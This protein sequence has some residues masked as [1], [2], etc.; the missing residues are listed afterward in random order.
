MIAEHVW[1][2]WTIVGEWS[3]A[4][5]PATPINLVDGA[6]WLSSFA[7]AQIEAYCPQ[8]AGPSQ[9]QAGQG[10]FFWNFKIETGYDEWNYL[11][12]VSQSWFSSN[13]SEYNQQFAFSCADLYSVPS[14]NEVKAALVTRNGTLTLKCSLFSF[15]MISLKAFSAKDKEKRPG[16]GPGNVFNGVN[17]GGFLVLE[18]WITPSLFANNSVQDG[19]GEWQ[20][21]A[22]RGPT[23][24]AQVM[25]QHWDTWVQQV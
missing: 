22:Q 19:L 23:V 12:G 25:N 15:I 6:G 4:I 11:L 5:G 17:L 24:A 14:P 1:S 21:C 9:V 2:D 8:C 13:A 10:Y 3:L 18:S 16:E 7:H 20:F